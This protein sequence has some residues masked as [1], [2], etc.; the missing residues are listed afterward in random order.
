MLKY[1]LL[2]ALN[3]LLLTGVA[4]A[5]DTKGVK[6][7]SL[8]AL[9]GSAP[10]I[11]EEHSLMEYKFEKGLRNLQPQSMAMIEMG[12]RALKEGRKG[13]AI[14]LF[15]A[16]KNLSPD[17]PQTYLYLAK[18][19]LS[20]SIEGIYAASGYLIQAAKAFGNNFWWSFLTAGILSLALVLSIYLST[21]IC[22]AILAASKLPMFI[23]D[24]TE[25]K[26]KILL[27]VPPIFL[28][29][30]GPI[31]GVLALL[32]PFWVFFRKNEKRIF[33]FILPLLMVIVLSMPFLS[34]FFGALNHSPIMRI[35]KIKEGVNT[36]ET[37]EGIKNSKRW[38]LGFAYAIDLKRKGRYEEAI[39]VYKRLLGQKPDA[40]VYNN[41]ANCYVALKE[42]DNG[43]SN[44]NKALRLA[45]MATTYYNLSQVYRETF[46]F[47][48]G[49]KYY[50]EALKLDPEK[51][52]Y[53]TTISGPSIN[54]FVI[55][56]NLTD[57]ELWYLT[58]DLFSGHGTPFDRLFSF[59]KQY[60]LLVFI[61]LLF[62]SLYTYSEFSGHRAYQCRRCGSVYC[63]KCERKLSR[64]DVCVRCYKTLVK[65]NEMEPKERVRK[66]LE[67]QGFKNNRS[68]KMKLLTI[69]LPG[70]GHIYYGKSLSGF[71]ILLLSIFFGS[72]VIL[73]NHVSLPL[74]M[75][76]I[77][78]PFSLISVTGLILIYG[79]TI[80]RVFRGRRWL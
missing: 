28:V 13:D 3:M 79:F 32:L 77:V 59:F 22:I 11:A 68:L 44:Y 45:E 38:E 23:H 16:A 6:S 57:K 60:L 65:M 52:A 46:R 35:V 31:F 7:S 73:W 42:Y 14:A 49:E 54:R 1:I 12:Q 25:N 48:E 51:T 50:Q 26:K 64:D 47:E 19:N 75:S 15:N 56:E 8:E 40:R 71:V 55:D 33:Y 30:L 43:I 53:F 34:S 39:N 58:F 20:P 21:A 69:F 2:M 78:F 66:L 36:S 9:Q 24:V 41:L 70:G 62:I 37:L 18:A 67:I 63:T 5:E 17:L 10:S 61:P 29:F 27:L 4:G 80:I 72:L 76:M 74:S